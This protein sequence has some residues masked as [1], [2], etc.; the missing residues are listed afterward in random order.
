VD[1]AARLSSFASRWV[2][3]KRNMTALWRNYNASLIPRS[4][5]DEAIRRA[6]AQPEMDTFVVLQL[7]VL[8]DHA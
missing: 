3:R 1:G 7:R 5:D 8:F 4:R 2:A 6:H